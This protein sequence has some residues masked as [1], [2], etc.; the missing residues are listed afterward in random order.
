[1][2]IGF[3]TEHRRKVEE[4]ESWVGQWLDLYF[5]PHITKAFKRNTDTET[6]KR[7]IDIYLS[8]S[9]TAFTLDEKASVQWVN[10]GLNKYSMELSILNDSGN[11]VNGWYMSDSISDCM[12]LVFIDSGET[13][14]ERY[15][16]S[17]SITQATYVLIDKAGFQEVL[18]D[19]GWNKTALINKN[20]R[21]RTAYNEY[22]DEYWRH[23]YCGKLDVD[24]I[25]FYVQTKDYQLERGINMQFSRDFLISHSLCTYKITRDKLERLK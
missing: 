2:N 17:S 8:G 16:A 7:G 10:Q 24:G 11:E 12:G 23:E 13:Y 4:Q 5:Y 14:N 20:N 6:Q 21:I 1:M 19:M 9:T 3:G 22:G 15:L 18:D 25:H